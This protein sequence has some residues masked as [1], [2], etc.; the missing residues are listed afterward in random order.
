MNERYPVFYCE[1]TGDELLVERYWCEACKAFTTVQVGR[2]AVADR[3]PLDGRVSPCLGC[4]EAAVLT[5]LSSTTIFKGPDGQELNPTGQSL[6]VGAVYH[7]PAWAASRPGPD[8]RHLV[9]VTPAGHWRID[10]RA[11]NCTMIDDDEH[12]CWIRHG[13]PEAGDLHV[14][15][16]G[17]TCAAGAGS[18]Q[19]GS[20][21]GF[22]H[23]GVLYK[24]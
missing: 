8:G 10:S 15:K 14:D 11:S 2:R 23:N 7:D 3:T 1:P 12:R 17:K 18:I 24:N 9:C 13:S 20:W 4:Q 5:S 6:P 22:L 19:M 16:N 21:H